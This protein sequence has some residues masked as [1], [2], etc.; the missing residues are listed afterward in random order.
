MNLPSAPMVACPVSGRVYG[1]CNDAKTILNLYDKICDEVEDVYIHDLTLNTDC[2]EDDDSGNE[3]KEPGIMDEHFLTRE[4]END[5]SMMVI[6]KKKNTA[7]VTRVKDFFV[8]M[9][10]GVDNT[11]IDMHSDCPGSQFAWALKSNAYL[12]GLLSMNY[13]NQQDKV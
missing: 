9:P 4:N 3:E 8:T 7:W 1:A 10:V 5:E 6:E 13:Y 11:V 2:M 12:E